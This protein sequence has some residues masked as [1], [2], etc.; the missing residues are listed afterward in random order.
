MVNYFN[1]YI[2]VYC[3]HN[4]DLKCILSGKAAKAAMCYITEYITKMELKTYEIL[5]LLSRAVASIPAQ[6]ELPLR[7]KGRLLLH[8]CLAQFTRQQQI[9]AQ[10]AARYLRGN[11]DT[12]SSHQ[13]IAMV[14]GLLLDFLK[15]EYNICLLENSDDECE[16][17]NIE[18][19]FLKI[20]TDHAGNLISHNQLTNYWY[21]DRALQNMN[22]YDFCRCITLQPKSSNTNISSHNERIGVQKKYSLLDGHPL[23][24]KYFLTQHTD[25]SSCQYGKQLVPRIVGSKIPRQN[26][27][28]LWMFFTLAHFKPFHVS[29]PFI[30][31]N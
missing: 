17:D 5:S 18:G 10:Q 22:F 31:K 12:I 19:T 26:D 16:I 4:H 2:L 15:V 8:K 13:T 25:D 7:Q 3:R 24:K 23:A 20:Q 9:H 6:P 11:D 21:R 30:E 14:S 27:H 28:Q 29:V 1:R